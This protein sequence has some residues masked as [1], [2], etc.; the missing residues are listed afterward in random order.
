V[1]SSSLG[2]AE[3]KYIVEVI[4]V[5]LVFSYAALSA[6]LKEAVAT[7]QFATALQALATTA[8]AT[9]LAQTSSEPV[10][11]VDTSPAA[12]AT[13]SNDAEAALSTGAIVG[14]IVGAVA[15]LVLLAVAFYFC[16]V[17]KSDK[18]ALR[19]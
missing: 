17:R 9:G 11:T 6:Q 13:K 5:G 3:V 8:G 14:I 18:V 2:T 1:T 12:P 4:N 19:Q 7:G 15:A 16:C 10:S